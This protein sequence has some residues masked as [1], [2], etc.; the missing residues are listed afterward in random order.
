[1]KSRLIVAVKRDAEGRWIGQ[2]ARIPGVEARGKTRREALTRVRALA[3]RALAEQVENGEQV[4]E[5]GQLLPDAQFGREE[6]QIG[7]TG[8]ALAA[9]IW[10]QEDFSDWEVAPNGKGSPP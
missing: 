7:Q 4:A 1:M 9:A 8:A 6:E 5:V 3:L 2:V 10:D